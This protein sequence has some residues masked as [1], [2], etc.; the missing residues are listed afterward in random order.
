MNNCWIRLFILLLP[1]TIYSKSLLAI[2]YEGI[3]YDVYS[4]EDKTLIVSSIDSR[5]RGRITSLDIPETIFAMNATYTVV[6]IRKWA[7]DFCTKLEFVNIPK[8]VF[9]IN[10]NLAYGDDKLVAYNVADDNPYFTSIDGVIY[11]KEIKTLIK[12]PNGKTEVVIPETLVEIGEFAFSGC[13]GISS[14][15]LPQ[16]VTKLGDD[17]FSYCYNL[18]R[19]ELSENIT[20]IGSS[21]FDHCEKLS[22]IQLPEKLT[23]LGSFAFSYCRSFETVKV[24]ESVSEWGINVFCDCTSLVSATL[25]ST[26]TSI[27]SG[28]FSGCSALTDVE[29]PSSVTCIE[30]GA[31]ADCKSLTSINIPKN[32]NTFEM[33]AFMNCKSLKSIYIPA[34]LEKISYLCFR[35][36]ESLDTFIVDENNK[37][38]LAEGSM[39]VSKDK[40]LLYAFPSAKG[41]EEIP[42]FITTIGYCSMA[43]C[44]NLNVITLPENLQLIDGSAFFDCLNLHRLNFRSLI[45]P[46]IGYTAFYT[47]STE[48]VY[49]EFYVPVESLNLYR[50]AF[51]YTYILPWK[52]A[53]VEVVPEIPLSLSYQVF[54]IDGRTVMITDNPD[55][56][57]FLPHGVY[58]VN[59]KKIIL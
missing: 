33:V 38:F 21:S 12:C 43:G 34:G 39:L 53:D 5:I 58:I 37:V 44:E 35:G 45:P 1:L 51:P 16:S 47:E 57:R 31:F 52:E 50:E 7:L 22:A 24:P 42:E 17:S 32:I 11:D 54:T 46:E 48:E 28:I 27:P 13:K 55:K 59:G 20:H 19:V 56:L 30:S 14:I 4:S 6:A 49:H 15:V 8:T 18:S 23:Y 40:S 2:D 9:E 10:G 41:E 26:L 29:I 25:P 3:S 36:C